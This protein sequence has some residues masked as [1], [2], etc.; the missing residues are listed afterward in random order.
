MATNVTWHYEFGVALDE[1]AFNLIS[2][3]LF[4]SRPEL[5]SYST[6]IIVKP[7]DPGPPPAPAHVLTVYAVADKPFSFSLYPVAGLPALP[8][9]SLLV[10]GDISFALT[11]SI[12]GTITRVGITL[13]RKS[14]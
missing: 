14:T 10:Q 12:L 8:A 1:A 13:D 2:A 11:D 4:I 6:D 5:F 7:A 9:D 3:G